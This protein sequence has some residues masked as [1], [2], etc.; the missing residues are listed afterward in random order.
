MHNMYLS[1]HEFLENFNELKAKL[2]VLVDS[3]NFGN[4]ETFRRHDSDSGG[5][6]FGIVDGFG[7]TIFEFSWDGNDKRM[8]L[9]LEIVN[10]ANPTMISLLLNHINELEN[11]V[12]ELENRL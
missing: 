4:W 3:S 6:I 1:D 11:Y 5:T 9:C 2:E 10:S 7:D 8:I 12:S